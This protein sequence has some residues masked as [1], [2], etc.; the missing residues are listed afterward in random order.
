MSTHVIEVD[1]LSSTSLLMAEIKF[2][3]LHRQFER[4]VNEFIHELGEI[5]R[6]TAELW[7]GDTIHVTLEEIPDGVAINANGKH[8]VFLEFGA[9]DAVN[10]ANRYA[11]TVEEE[12]GMEIR[13]GSYSEINAHQYERTGQWVFGGVIYTEVQ[14]RNAMEHTY[15]VIQQEMREVARRVFG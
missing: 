2:R 3:L 4:K 11:G 12:S 7:Y 14:P 1:P 9:G 13:P 8:V 5:G 15:E 6:D 10:S